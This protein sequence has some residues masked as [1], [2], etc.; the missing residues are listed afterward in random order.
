MPRER[1]GALSRRQAGR[2]VRDDLDQLH[3]VHGI[4]EMHADQSR[5]LGQR[6]GDGGD[7]QRRR[8]RS[9]QR[10]GRGG[11]FDIDEQSLL[12][13]EILHHGFNDHIGV[14]QRRAELRFRRDPGPYRRALRAGQLAALDATLEQAVD[15]GECRGKRIGSR[16]SDPHV[17]AGERR[18]VGDAV[19]H[20]A[21]ADDRD[22]RPHVAR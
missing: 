16:V 2:T 10:V 4:E 22:A 6:R 21:G 11:A 5:G 14:P 17:A 8:V 7:R 13:R 1:D 18:G 20:G 9:E 15:L 3:D 19:A 12:D